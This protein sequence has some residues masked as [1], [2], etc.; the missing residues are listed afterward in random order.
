MTIYTAI[1][2]VSFAETPGRVDPQTGRVL[3]GPKI[4]S[5]NPSD[6]FEADSKVGDVFVA[7]GAAVEKSSV[8]KPK[9]K[10]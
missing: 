8:E 5:V 3:A 9:G 6:D 7:A 1:H 4:K 10:G 2:A